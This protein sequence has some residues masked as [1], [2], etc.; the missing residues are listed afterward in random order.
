M[1]LEATGAEVRLGTRSVLQDVSFAVESGELVAVC[2]PNGAGKSTLLRCL[3]G[4]LRPSAGSV[5]LNGVQIFRLSPR[6]RARRVAY[7]PQDP[8]LPVGFR[9]L[10]VVR[11]GR[12]AAAWRRSWGPEEDR[13]AINVMRLTG[14]EHLV[15][16]RVEETSGGERQRVL[17]SRVLA[18]GARVL[19]LDEPTAHLDLAAQARVVELLRGLGKAGYAVV[20]ATHDLN[21]ASLFFDRVVLLCGGRVLQDG[22]PQAVLVPEVVR[23]AYGDAA[24]LVNHPQVHR[25]VVLPR[26][27]GM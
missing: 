3:A 6:E 18:Q 10:E 24:V 25:P 26:A 13:E 7:L 9:C 23:A 15:E 19:L 8:A 21:V 20:A 11:M 27:E 4:L 16:R 12:Y 1:R 22:P 14:T 17:L 2:G 5:R